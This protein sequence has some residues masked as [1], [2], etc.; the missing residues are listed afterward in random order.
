[1]QPRAN[2]KSFT[3]TSALFYLGLT[4]KP[5]LCRL[6]ALN[7][8]QVWTQATTVLVAST[9][10]VADYDLVLKM[11]T[12]GH[13]RKPSSARS[14]RREAK[15]RSRADSR[16]RWKRVWFT[17]TVTVW[18]DSLACS[19]NWCEKPNRYLRP[20]ADHRVLMILSFGVFRG[21][22]ESSCL[23]TRPHFVAWESS[24]ALSWL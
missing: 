13:P 7:V 17:L 8:F 1:M 2:Q 19:H 23:L 18:A 4:S 12:D 14:K 11:R 10:K 16:L 20:A 6:T 22:T 5:G 3:L 21:P 24:H 9:R 15:K